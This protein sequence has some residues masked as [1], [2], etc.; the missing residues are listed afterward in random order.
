MISNFLNPFR[1]V[2]FE[3]EGSP[4]IYVSDQAMQQFT[5]GNYFFTGKRGCGKTS[6]LKISDTL[7]QNENK[8]FRQSSDIE[9]YKTTF[10]VYINLNNRSKPNFF[11]MR[12][13]KANKK[14]LISKDSKRELTTY[15]L[16][17]IILHKVIEHCVALRDSAVF[18]V[19]DDCERGIANKRMPRV[20]RRA[21]EEPRPPCL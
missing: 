3:D 19:D 17:L 6:I 5:A 1:P 21:G 14:Y 9:Q 15:Y 16:E 20:R 2:K 11:T 4:L 8:N 12:E 13:S 7:F 18:K 10:G